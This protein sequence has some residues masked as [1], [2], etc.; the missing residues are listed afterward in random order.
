MPR[1]MKSGVNFSGGG[2]VKLDTSLTQSGKAADAKAVGDMLIASDN[3]PF[4]FGVTEDGK[5]GYII[6]DEAGA[7]TVIPFKSGEGSAEDLYDALK[8]SGL[9]TEDM[10]YA[11]MLEALRKEYPEKLI[12]YSGTANEANFK[13]VAC[14]TW[15]WTPKAAAVSVGSVLTVSATPGGSAVAY[16]AASNLVDFT[17]WKKLKFT[18]TSSI[19]KSTD[20]DKIKIVITKSLPSVNMTAVLS[21][22]LVAVNGSLSVTGQTVEID[23]S[24][25]SGE[26]YIVIELQT[27]TNTGTFKTAISNMYLE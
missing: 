15:P 17:N 2:S 9:V 12:L 14:T 16:S 10:T 5:Y 22:Q 19:P 11:E 21:H 4:R 20:Y 18:H 24:S 3:T 27:N 7:D 13:G 25:L 23:V 1:I 6:T 26:Y 8:Y